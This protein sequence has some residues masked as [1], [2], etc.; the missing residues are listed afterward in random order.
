MSAATC[1]EPTPAE[2]AR[3]VLSAA[4]SLT[5]TT[6]GHRVELIGLHTVD[7]AARLLLRN[8]PDAHLVA[9]LAMAPHGDPA[10]LV[11]FT[12]IAPVAVR[13]RVRARL[14]L[15]GRLTALGPKAVVFNTARAVLTEDDGTTTIG[16]DEL[17]L[18]SPDP[19]A[20][21]EAEMLARLDAAHAD[22]VAPLTRLLPPRLQLGAI[23]VRPLRLDRHGLV[24]RVQTPDAHHD[25]RLPFAAPATHPGEAV[26]QFHLLLARATA[27]PRR[28][29]PTRS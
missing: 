5:V 17:T 8:P 26:R 2:R 16:L 18:A 12:D 14:T 27:R 9:E 22:T 1:P 10:S 11:E 28:R 25:A 21:H 4:G 13:D 3:S 6:H 20:T 29:L 23:E 15:G 7:A 19:L 24:L